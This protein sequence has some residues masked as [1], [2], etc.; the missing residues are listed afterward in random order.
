MY[1]IINKAV[2]D[3][4][5]THHGE[6][7]GQQMKRKTGAEDEIFISTKSHPNEVTHELIGATSEVLGQSTA[8]IVKIIGHGRGCVLEAALN[9]CGRLLT[10]GQ[11]TLEEFLKNLPNF[12]TRVVTMFPAQQPPRFDCTNVKPTELQ[13]QD[14]RH[15]HG[16]SALM[17]G[18]LEGLA[19]MF[20][21]EVRIT[22]KE[23]KACGAN[24]D[25][26]QIAWKE[27]KTR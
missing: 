14:R 4:L 19:E 13:L 21:L 24:H 17:T 26:I 8:K 15:R 23:R 27:P 3:H 16:L 1:R 2:P 12:H 11:R 18:Q 20:V 10:I 5:F 6:D 22:Q 9:S 25:A 7:T